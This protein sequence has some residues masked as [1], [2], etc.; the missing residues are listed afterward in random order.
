VSCNGGASARVVV[1]NP[2]G[3]TIST[4]VSI[5]GSAINGLISCT[6]QQSSYSMSNVTLNPGN[7]AFVIGGL[8]TGMWVHAIA[9]SIGA[10]QYNQY[11]KGVVLK[12][13]DSGANPYSRVDWRYFPQSIRVKTTGDSLGGTCGTNCTFR[14]AL[15]TANGM[16]TSASNPL[17]IYFTV[18]PGT[19]TQTATLAVNAGG[20]TQTGH[21]TIDG[22]NSS[23]NP[24]IVGDALSSQD[25]FPVVIDLANKTKLSLF[26]SNNTLKGLAILNTTA[27]GT[28]QVELIADNSGATNTTLHSLRLDGGAGSFSSCSSGCAS[29]LVNLSQGGATITNLEGRSAHGYGVYVPTGLASPPSIRDSWF[30]HNLNHNLLVNNSTLTRNFVELAGYRTSD[31]SFINT[32]AGIFGSGGSNIATSRNVVR[33]NS[34]QGLSVTAASGQSP[35]LSL[36]HDYLC[37]NGLE[38]GII[39]GGGGS[40][41]GTGLTAAYND[42]YGLHFHSSILNGSMTFNNNSAFTANSLQGL[43]NSSTAV[44]VSATNNQWRGVT[45]T[46]L[47]SCTTSGDVSGNVSCNPAQDY[48]NVPAVIDPNNPTFPSNVLRSG[49]TIRVQGEGFNA[50]HGNPL[51]SEGSCTIGPGASASN[52]CRKTSKAN[53]CAGSP[54]QGEAGKGNCTAIRDR[55]GTWNVASPVAVTPTT[56]STA[57]PTS[58]ACIGQFNELIRVSK[59]KGDGTQSTSERPYCTNTDPK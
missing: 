16:S 19:M 53:T 38:G 46:P 44:T 47:P 36:S 37:G 31:N 25:S 23:G 5:S 12:A 7:N 30:H 57:L 54:P 8:N 24:W 20:G 32:A 26:G 43:R 35:I 52:C 2:T 15:S 45:G 33:N 50:I 14:Q 6:D 55:A 58:I 9:V 42:S 56:I 48:V 51:A 4:G 10:N 41:T 39:Y 17:L 29:R 49:Q 28:P 21:I 3:S 34:D 27:S 18:S 11:Q 40:A 59:R 1:N 13:P 22:T